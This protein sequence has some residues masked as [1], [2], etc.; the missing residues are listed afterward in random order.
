[1]EMAASRG[2]PIKVAQFDFESSA[3]RLRSF[4][5]RF[6][7]DRPVG[8]SFFLSNYVVVFVLCFV[9]VTTWTSSM[10]TEYQTRRVNRLIYSVSMINSFGRNYNVDEV[11]GGANTCPSLRFLCENVQVSTTVLNRLNL[12][13]MGEKKT[14]TFSKTQVFEVCQG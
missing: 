11:Y 12:G 6:C 14:S 10:E 1:M 7:F 4:Y 3:S 5:F 8:W 2:A 13:R 9:F